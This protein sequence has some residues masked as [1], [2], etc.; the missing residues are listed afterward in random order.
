LEK[1]KYFIKQ[2]FKEKKMVGAVS[3]S[4]KFLMRKMLSNINF[5]KA[6]LIIEFGPGTGVFTREIAQRMNPECK[7]IVFELHDAFFTK[8]SEEF[9]DN[10]SVLL[11]NE[12]AENISI[13]LNEKNLNGID[14][15]ISSLPLANFPRELI[16]SILSNGVSNLTK[17][18]KF[19]QFQY[20]LSA[21]KHFQDHFNSVQI[22]FTARNLP[23]AFI[24]TCS[25]ISKID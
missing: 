11:R 8:L 12:S 23:P 16:H 7:L 21:K 24:Y 17:D 9:Q 2:F 5:K 20:S 3:P 13:A 6:R 18:G 10:P 22:N 15:I 1:K 14:V 4:S 25:N 19:I